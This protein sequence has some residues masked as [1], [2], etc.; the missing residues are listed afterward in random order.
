M[1]NI[2]KLLKE[3]FFK[4]HTING[5]RTT[6]GT[7]SLKSLITLDKDFGKRKFSVTVNKDF[8]KGV[9]ISKDT[10]LTDKDFLKGKTINGNV[11]L[12]SI[13]TADKDFLKGTTING[14]LDLSHMKIADRDFLKETNFN[15]PLYFPKN[16]R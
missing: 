8:L 7:L 2:I 10:I 14:T 12:R 3:Y 6:N 16:R 15:S 5:T 9:T 11:D 4:N 1:K 13:T